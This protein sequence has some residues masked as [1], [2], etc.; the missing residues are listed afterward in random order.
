M[1]FDKEGLWAACYHIANQKSYEGR[2][3]DVKVIKRLADILYTNAL[4]YRDYLEGLNVDPNV[5]VRA[6]R[7]L[8]STHTN[9]YLNDDQ[10]LISWFSNSLDI[11]IE[12]VSPHV[13]ISYDSALFL[14]DVQAGVS[15]IL[16]PA[17]CQPLVKTA[18]SLK[19][20]EAN[21]S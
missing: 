5:L 8:A 10:R 15:R 3:V 11:L 16:G 4:F 17:E 20:A 9:P 13:K 19:D 12:L 6:V 1:E 7:Y 18:P 2:P 14:K 21:L